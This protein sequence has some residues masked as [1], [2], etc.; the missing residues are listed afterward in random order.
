[1]QGEKLEVTDKPMK[2]IP[3]LLADGRAFHDLGSSLDSH[4]AKRR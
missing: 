4:G 3:V 2:T 1:M